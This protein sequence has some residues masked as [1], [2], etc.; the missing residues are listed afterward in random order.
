MAIKPMEN[1]TTPTCK[2]CKDTNFDLQHSLSMG[3]PDG[4]Q[5]VWRLLKCKSCGQLALF[6]YETKREEK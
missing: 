2:W 4:S 5:T 1:E 6:S 3:D